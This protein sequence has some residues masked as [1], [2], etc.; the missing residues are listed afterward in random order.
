MAN[1]P[2]HVVLPTSA[3]HNGGTPSW[4]PPGG[5]SGQ[6]AGGLQGAGSSTAQQHASMGSWTNPTLVLRGGSDHGG[7][8]ASPSSMGAAAMGGGGSGGGYF[9][10]VQFTNAGG[11]TS[12]LQVTQTSTPATS[13]SRQSTLPSTTTSPQHG[14]SGGGIGLPPL[15]PHRMGLG[16]SASPPSTQFHPATASGAPA[17]SAQG[18]SP[19]A[20]PSP[21]T[22]VPSVMVGITASHIHKPVNIRVGKM[23]SQ[24]A[25]HYRPSPVPSASASGSG[26]AILPI[27]QGSPPVLP[28]EPPRH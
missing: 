24:V 22:P 17:G 2:F 27:A 9:F 3:T 8:A 11:I 20:S 4:T 13:A 23:G 12:P 25:S 1:P 7:Y 5:N 26:G 15:P 19:P 14:G 28:A 16:P 18:G 6:A 10:P 21:P